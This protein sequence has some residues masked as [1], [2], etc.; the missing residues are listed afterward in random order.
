MKPSRRY[1]QNGQTIDEAGRY[2]RF[3]NCQYETKDLKEIAFLKG[4]PSFG[5]D[6][7]VVKEDAIDK[8]AKVRAQFEADDKVF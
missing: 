1:V 6:I 8:V 7:F 4:H 3:S 2:I 5:K